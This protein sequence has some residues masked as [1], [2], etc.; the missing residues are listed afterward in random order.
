[1]PGPTTGA[2]S[3]SRTGAASDA[4]TSVSAVSVPSLISGPPAAWWR[5]GRAHLGA[6]D[7]GASENTAR[8]SRARVALERHR[9]PC[10]RVV[11]AER[12]THPVVGH[13][14]PDQ[15]RMAGEFDAVHVE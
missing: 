5:A 2:S 8:S 14:D 13:Q 3:G 11:L 15:V 7:V 1:M 10:G 6:R 12:M 9:H 4:L